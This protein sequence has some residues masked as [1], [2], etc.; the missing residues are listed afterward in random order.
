MIL[1]RFAVLFIRKIKLQE[2]FGKYF[3]LLLRPGAQEFTGKFP[4]VPVL[5]QKGAG[6]TGADRRRRGF[7]FLFF[8]I[9]LKF[10]RIKKVRMYLL[11]Y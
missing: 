2:F 5:T 11:I 7:F 9:N 1:N 6:A 3:W 4:G 10:K 8:F